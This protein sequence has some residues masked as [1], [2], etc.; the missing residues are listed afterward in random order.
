MTIDNNQN[1]IDSRDIIDRIAELEKAH[2]TIADWQAEC[3]EE[4]VELKVLSALA[5]G[6][7]QY[8]PDWSYGAALIRAS[9]FTEYCKELLS[10]YG[11]IQHDLPAYIVVDYTAVDFGGVTYLIR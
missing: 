6:A 2:D 3:P 8:I 10:D 11:Y 5:K 9:Y 4:V 7:E 1:V